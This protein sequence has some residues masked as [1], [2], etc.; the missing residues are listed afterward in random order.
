MEKS[1][2]MLLLVAMFALVA[3][4]NN[5][6]TPQRSENDIIV[7]NIIAQCK[8]FETEDI[9]QYISGEW[10]QDASLI[11]NEDWSAIKAAYQISGNWYADGGA[12]ITYIFSANGKGSLIS[13]NES[14]GPDSYIETYQFDWQYDAENR[15]FT[16]IG[17]N[18]NAKYTVSG[19]NDEYIIFDDSSP[20][21]NYRKIFKK[22]V[23]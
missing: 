23:K 9:T 16:M 7:D 12:D 3:C 22:T 19:F 6:R 11:Y 18:F 13:N 15:Q 8:G 4:D 1:Y 20:T 21:R 5:E 2:L 17:N 10:K 14:L